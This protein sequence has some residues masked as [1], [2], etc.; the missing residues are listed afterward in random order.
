LR[1]GV[2]AVSSGIIYVKIEESVRGCEVYVVEPTGP[3]V[4]RHLMELLFL[5]DAVASGGSMD[6]V[7]LSATI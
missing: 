3:P 4:D 5:A 2:V 6:L 7:K 1:A